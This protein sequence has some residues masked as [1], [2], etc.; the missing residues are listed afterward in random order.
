MKLFGRVSVLSLMALGTVAYAA[1]TKKTEAVTK[2]ESK[3]EAKTEAKTETKSEMAE[4]EDS[5]M[6]VAEDAGLSGDAQTKFKDAAEARQ[7]K[8]DAWSE[9]EKGKQLADLKKELTAARKAKDEAKVKTLEEQAAPLEKEHAELMDSSRGE[10][11]GLLSDKEW[12][13][14]ISASLD[15]RVKKSLSAVTLT[16]D[17]EEKIKEI[18]DEAVPG[19]LKEHTDKEQAFKGLV[20]LQSKVSAKVKSDVLTDAQREA[21]KAAKPAKPE[22]SAEPTTK[23]AK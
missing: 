1:D 7:K 21:I 11:L 16:K 10:V 8:L 4:K 3:T 15:R 6:A 23:P 22:K 14:A 20:G 12:T 9:S 19:Y 18:S 13:K 17:Q 2:T 5:L